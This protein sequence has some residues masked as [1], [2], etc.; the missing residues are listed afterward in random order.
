MSTNNGGIM[1]PEPAIH[2]EST[3]SP[4]L[5][6]GPLY[7]PPLDERCPVRGGKPYCARHN[8]HKIAGICPECPD[9]DDIFGAPDEGL[10]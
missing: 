5:R 2:H 3:A 9:A 4:A 8:R 6:E 10:Y 7:M 1:R